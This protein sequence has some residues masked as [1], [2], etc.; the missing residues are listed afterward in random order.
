MCFLVKILYVRPE[1]GQDQKIS[2]FQVPGLLVSRP[3]KTR[4][5]FWVLKT[6]SFIKANEGKIAELAFLIADF[7][8]LTDFRSW[9]WWISGLE[10]LQIYIQILKIS[11]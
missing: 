5:I 8:V 2:A 1:I 11:L 9:S 7:L 10:I 4:Y 3:G 6:R